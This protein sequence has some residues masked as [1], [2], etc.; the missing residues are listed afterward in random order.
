[1]WRVHTAHNGAD[2]MLCGLIER[3]TVTGNVEKGALDS[4][5]VTD[6]TAFENVFCMRF[7]REK[8]KCTFFFAMVFRNRT[9]CWEF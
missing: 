7:Y 9:R 3:F 8:K 1:M 2:D 6:W 4:A 5:S